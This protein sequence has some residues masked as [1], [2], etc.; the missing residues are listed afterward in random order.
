MAAE[1]GINNVYCHHIFIVVD[2]L[3]NQMELQVHIS[4]FCRNNLS[5]VAYIN[6]HNRMSREANMITASLLLYV[7]YPR[8]DFF[9]FLAL[10][11]YWVAG[12]TI[13][14]YC[15]DRSES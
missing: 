2:P 13:T 14:T 10:I 5:H 11:M 1:N 3:A 7:Y 6:S 9:S 15:I 8:Y 4:V 12:R